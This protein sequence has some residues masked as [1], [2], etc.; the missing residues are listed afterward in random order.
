MKYVKIPSSF[1]VVGTKIDVRLVDRC[2]DN[3]FGSCFLGAGYIEIANIVNKNDQQSAD[4]KQHESERIL[5]T[6]F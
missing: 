3:V 5:L 4:S 2:D 6:S 1:K